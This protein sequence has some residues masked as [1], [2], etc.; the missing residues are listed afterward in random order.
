MD[1]VLDVTSTSGKL[2]KTAGRDAARGKNTYPAVLGVSGARA[3]AELLI[4]EG[5]AALRDCGLLTRE[6]SQ[7]ANFMVTR[8]S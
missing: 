7:V 5:S 4:D 2:G 6:L 1:D 3:R 8:T